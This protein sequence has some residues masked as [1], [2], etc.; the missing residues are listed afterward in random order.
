MKQTTG[1]SGS[2]AAMTARLGLQGRA[3]PCSSARVACTAE[4][5]KAE[6]APAAEAASRTP[7]ATA[8]A[9]AASAGASFPAFT[10]LHNKPV[11]AP[12]RLRAQARR[13]YFGLLAVPVERRQGMWV[14]RG[15]QLKEYC[16]VSQRAGDDGADDA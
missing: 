14:S 3:D 8:K 12:T 1:P 4:A 9:A 13:W 6:A 15:H 7:I 16:D 5:R 11:R 10:E 2:Y